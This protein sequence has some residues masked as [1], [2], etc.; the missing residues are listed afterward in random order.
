MIEDY[1]TGDCP[2]R[3]L[4]VDVTAGPFTVRRSPPL[5][6]VLALGVCLPV[7][8]AAQQ[9]PCD[10]RTLDNARGER[11]GYQQRDPTRCEGLYGSDVSGQ[12]LKVVSLTAGFD[13]DTASR[14]PLMLT[15]SAPAGSYVRLLA[16]ATKRDLY[17]RMD[18]RPETPGKFEW[19]SALLH[20]RRITRNDIGL[21]GLSDQSAGNEQH[22]L[23]VPLRISQEGGAPSADSYE[24]Q[25]LP[26]VRLSEVR[27]SLASVPVVGGRP[28]GALIRDQ[29]P[30]RR[31]SFPERRPIK[32][33]IP[34]SELPAPGIYLVEISAKRANG[35]AVAA[36]PIWFYHGGT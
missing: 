1:P 12:V 21:L 26:N 14:K 3:S 33:V 31:R 36:T 9:S 35:R 20:A 8:S 28:T 11:N 15:W 32:I 4:E 24:L 29:Q 17:Y 34:Y 27:V 7:A 30:V 16:Q 5:L 19:P 23:L 22:E 25:L 13:Y 18:A 6:A 10:Q 2:R